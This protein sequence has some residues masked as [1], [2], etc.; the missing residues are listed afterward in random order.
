MRAILL[1]GL[2]MAATVAAAPPDKITD[3]QKA[4]AK[5]FFDAGTL[6][7]DQGQF[8]DA[9][10]EFE[11]AYA[12]APLP[13]FL[14]NIASS[15][16]KAGDRPKAAAAYRHYAQVMPNAK[17]VGVA[18]ARAD[19][20]ERE[21]KELEAAKRSTAAPPRRQLPPPLPFVEPITRYTYQT[22][23]QWD[24]EPYT[25][26][27]VGARKVYGFKVYAMALYVEDA[28]ARAAFP[29]LA[30]E[31]GG[32]DH[33]TLSRGD[34]ANQWLVLSEFGKSAVLH[35]VRSVSA[36]DT[37]D[38]YREALGDDAND[39]AP[40]NLKRDAEAFLNLFDDVKD[41]DNLTIRTR[42]D[43]Q[44]IVETHGKVKMGPK[45]LRL[46]HDLW[47]IWMG[48][49]PISSDLKKSLIDRIDTLGR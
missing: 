5:R 31:A 13:A 45:N 20:L 39:K 38:A 22:L 44:I 2:A 42:S 4:A 46:S 27:G 14:Y 47:D 7:F 48:A 37:R 28:P 32:S 15:Y 23:M 11:R 30:G 21:W 36:K 29:K 24:N 35:F 16:D 1:A 25:L 18:R 8:A 41:G 19:V 10:K 26:L 43:G 3:E 17:D 34:L 49:K 40:S 9:A 6:L 33:A 12:Q